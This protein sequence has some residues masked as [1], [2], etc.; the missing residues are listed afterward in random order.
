MRNVAEQSTTQERW[1]QYGAEREKKINQDPERYV[2]SGCPIRFWAFD[3]EL[4]ELINPIRNKQILEVGCGMGEFSVW[5]AKQGGKVTGVDIGAGLVAA[6]KALARVNRV[7]CDFQQGSITNLSF[8]DSDSCDIVIGLAILHHLSKAD[9]LKSLHECHRVLKVGG[10]AIFH[11]SVENSKLFDFFQNLFPVGK[12][13]EPDHRP[14]ILQRREWVKYVEALDDRSMTN[15]ELVSAG[16]QLFSGISISPYGF[17]IRLDRLI[18]SHRNTLM[19][20]DG[21]LFKFLP[22][23]KY[24]CQSVLVQY[25]K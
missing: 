14:S 20:L 5:L 21:F 16:R 9:V 1:H 25:R 22:P 6:S 2:I 15:Q 4:L 10:I 18:Y 17:L 7:E 24:Y 19:A 3:R 12:R 8:V 13:G 11:E 23:L